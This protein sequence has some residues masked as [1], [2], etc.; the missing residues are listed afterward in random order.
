MPTIVIA[1][2]NEGKARE[3][4]A[5]LE[6][7]G[8]EVKTLLD[9]PDI[10]DVEETGYTFEENARLKAETISEKLNLPVLADDSG[11]MVDELDG[12]P[13]V[14]SA[15]FA[16]E[17]KNDARNNAKLLS[18]LGE[19]ENSSRTARFHC[20]LVASRPGKESLVVEGEVEGEIAKIP[21]GENG[22]GYDPL[23]LL[24]EKGKTMAQLSDE[25]KNA[26]SHRAVALRKFEKYIDE[27]FK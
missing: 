17:P 21:A 3:F 14:F 2:Q 26:I 4:K 8:Y 16:G 10:P 11:L 27:W 13:G 1:T 5:M 7:K 6:P 18:M 25:E 19:F 15:R 9:Y 23:F 12:A 22:F 24:P 20:T